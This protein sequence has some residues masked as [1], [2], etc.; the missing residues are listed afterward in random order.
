MS[1]RFEVFRLSLL[2]RPQRDLE[3][4][5][6]PTREEYLRTVFS[7]I[8]TFAHYNA[9]FHFRP[10][11]RLSTDNGLIG[12]LGRA[13]VIDENRPP[14][15]GFEEISHEGWKACVVVVDPGEHEDGQKASIEIDQAVGKP[16][17]IFGGLVK[18]INA[19]NPL[20]P[21]TI[22]AQP[23]FDAETF[24]DFAEENEGQITSLTFEFVVPNGLWSASSSIRDELKAAK[25]K[26]GAQK[27]INTFQSSDGIETNSEQVRDAVNYAVSGS[28][29]IK[30][31]AKGGK[32]FDSNEKPKVATLPKSDEEKEPV[33]VRVARNIA[34]VLGRE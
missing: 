13:V 20:A 17:A 25:E 21:Y 22:E 10:D 32:K 34:R 31:R 18:A 27:V 29:E 16:T 14:D 3:G 6:D 7:A 11:P 2:P 4:G 9:E 26:L 5:P 1:E 24:W 28:G 23:I 15:Q 30:A 33:I 19:A 12:R 8:T